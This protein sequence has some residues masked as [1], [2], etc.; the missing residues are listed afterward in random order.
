MA[1]AM[2]VA[3]LG[4]GGWG[5]ALGRLLAGR[6]REVRL[7]ARDPARV[8]EMRALGE[9]RVYLPGQ[10]FPKG[11]RP[12]AVLGEALEGAELVVVAVPVQHIR[13]TLSV[14]RPWLGTGAIV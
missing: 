9:N 10:A 13:Q 1:E 12:T 11:L 8:E 2:P 5:T 14:A 3:V 7:W 6:G 4:A